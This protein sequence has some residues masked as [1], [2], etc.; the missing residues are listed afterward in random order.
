MDY[1][2][3]DFSCSLLFTGFSGIMVNGRRKIYDGNGS[4]YYAESGDLD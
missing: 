4:D 1:G 3:Q 2:L